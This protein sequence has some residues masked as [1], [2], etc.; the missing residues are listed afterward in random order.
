MCYAIRI[1]P[2]DH[3]SGVVLPLYVALDG[4]NS[5]PL[6]VEPRLIGVQDAEL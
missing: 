5:M 4:N 2:Q 6:Y 1:A 3:C